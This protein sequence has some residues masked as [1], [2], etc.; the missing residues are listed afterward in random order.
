L[1]KRLVPQLF[2]DGVRLIKQCWINQ[3][4][5][6]FQDRSLLGDL[7][8]NP[9]HDAGTDAECSADLEN[10]VAFGPQFDYARLHRW[11]DVPRSAAFR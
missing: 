4:S 9:L 2:E 8:K 1:R 3:F 5:F 7:P 6:G 10:A 11:A